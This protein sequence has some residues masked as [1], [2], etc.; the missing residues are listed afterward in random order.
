M[1]D[2]CEEVT[3]VATE[4]MRISQHD[5]V[6][7]QELA[8]LAHLLPEREKERF[9]FMMQGVALMEDAKQRAAVS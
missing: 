8:E 7:D 3:D 2:K 5:R 9:Y 6:K 1:V 4:E